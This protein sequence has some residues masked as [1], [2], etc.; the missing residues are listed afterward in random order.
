MFFAYFIV[1][2]D[3]RLF[4]LWVVRNVNLTHF[5]TFLVLKAW[6]LLY[7]TKRLNVFFTEKIGIEV[8]FFTIDAILL[9]QFRLV[10][11]LGV[12]CRR[13]INKLFLEKQGNY[14]KW[15]ST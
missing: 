2:C 8:M 3:Q 7:K 14:L 11:F 9:N 15:Q 12:H 1:L 10:L 6:F 5:T 13:I 4:S